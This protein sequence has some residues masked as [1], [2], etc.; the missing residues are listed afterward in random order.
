MQVFPSISNWEGSTS[1]LTAIAPPLHHWLDR[2][3]RT[4]R[5]WSHDQEIRCRNVF[6]QWSSAL[7]LIL[8]RFKRQSSQTF[9]STTLKVFLTL[10]VCVSRTSA[11]VPPGPVQPVASLE[12][13]ASW[14]VSDS[15]V[16]AAVAGEFP[17]VAFPLVAFPAQNNWLWRAAKNDA[18]FRKRAVIV[19]QSDGVPGVVESLL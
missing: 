13:G 6:I 11:V 1:R 9:S 10:S 14:T 8:T 16:N 4:T 15:R 2:V 12:T 18:L 19:E 7:P 3:Y 17:L 5:S